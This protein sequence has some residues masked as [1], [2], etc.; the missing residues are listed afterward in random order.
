MNNLA[1]IGI[2]L[3]VCDTA[4]VTPGGCAFTQPH[5]IC[6]PLHHPTAPGSIIT[7]DDDGDGDY[8]SVQEAVQNANPGDTI[9]VYSGTYYETNITIATSHI[10]LLGIPHELGNGSG[11]GKPF[12]NGQGHGAA[13]WIN[14][15]SVVFSGFHV[16]N[17]ANDSGGVDLA[18]DGDFIVVSNND[19]SNAYFALIDCGHCHNCS[20]LNNTLS[21]TNY[22]AAI[23]TYYLCS[24][25][26]VAGNTISY[27]PIGVE[28]WES[29]HNIVKRNTI[30]HCWHGIDITSD[31]NT[32]SRNALQNNTLGITISGYGNVVRQNNFINNKK[33]ATFVIPPSMWHGPGYIRWIRNYWNRS[34]MF[35]Y[36]IHGMTFLLPW[37]NVD[38]LP[39]LKPYDTS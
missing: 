17:W 39:A 22:E 9:E 26:T 28:L 37:L 13:V 35:P 16:E 30:T 10:T 24:Y 8:L 19:I 20:I 29:P 1:I 3:L 2:L 18:I 14:A 4:M 38:W 11:S 33:H 27:A 36:V 15:S 23:A 7:V 25:L 31:K 34:R 5:A 21:H 12:V 32:I 6:S